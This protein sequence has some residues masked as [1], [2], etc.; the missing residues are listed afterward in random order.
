MD[1]GHTV[2]LILGILGVA[3]AVVGSLL[4]S[5]GKKEDQKL[6]AKQQSFDQLLDL[7]QTRAVEIDRL[8]AALTELHAATDARIERQR[9]RCQAVTDGLMRAIESQPGNRI[10]DDA[11]RT[12]TEHREDDHPGSAD[13]S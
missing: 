10:T 4:A 12:L 6:A 5:M 9:E 1:I 11:I 8:S 2:S 3:G 7:A 13:R